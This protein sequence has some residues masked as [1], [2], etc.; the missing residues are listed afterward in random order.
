MAFIEGNGIL[1]EEQHGFRTNRS[2]ES[3]LQSF[4]GGIQE[5]IDKKMNQIGLLLDLTKAYD[6]LD[7]KLLLFKLSKYGIRGVTISSFE[8]YLFNRKQCVVVDNRKLGRCVSSTRHTVLAVP[9][10][11]ILGPILFSLYINDLP[12]NMSESKLV[13]FADDTNI[14][15]S[16]ENLH[17]LQH[18]LTNIVSELQL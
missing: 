12:L 1:T 3:A 5:A 18:K 17:T 8:S 15:V 2:T 13:L 6:V 7:H 10:G 9:Q 11:S 14:L 16:G 4:I